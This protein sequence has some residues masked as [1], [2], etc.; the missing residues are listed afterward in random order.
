MALV[1]TFEA[2]AEEAASTSMPVLRHM[3]LEFP[4][5]P[6]VVGLSDQ[7][8]LGSDLLV[9]PVVTEG[10]VEREVYF[11]AGQWHHALRAGEMVQ[12]PGTFTVSAPLGE[13]PVFSRGA[14]R[15]DL[16]AID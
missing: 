16:R 13:P 7:F 9:A 3:I 8:M 15:S 6:A 11:P 2:L 12:G 4:D 14:E 10:A 1:P 5:D